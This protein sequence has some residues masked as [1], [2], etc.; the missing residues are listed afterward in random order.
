MVT[1]P[2]HNNILA[3]VFDAFYIVLNTL[4]LILSWKK[5]AQTCCGYMSL[6]LAIEYLKP[7]RYNCKYQQHIKEMKVELLSW[8]GKKHRLPIGWLQQ[9]LQN[10]FLLKHYENHHVRFFMSIV[11]ICVCSSTHIFYLVSITTQWG[12]KKEILSTINIK[13]LRS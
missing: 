9:L 13:K 8:V 2:L 10:F 7:M 12:I 6:S 5:S 1:G 11:C 3:C 4:Q